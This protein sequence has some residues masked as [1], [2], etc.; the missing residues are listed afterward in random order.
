MSI[1]GSGVLRE[2]AWSLARERARSIASTLETEWVPVADLDGRVLGEDCFSR[3]PLPPFDTSAMDGWAVSGDG[4]WHLVGES[5]AGAPLRGSLI[6]GQAIRIATGAVVPVG[7]TSVV[8]WEEAEVSDGL[9]RGVSHSGRDIRRAGEECNTGEL[10]AHRGTDVTPALA[11]FLAATGHDQV[12][13]IR[14]PRVGLVL[15]GD[16]LLESGIPAD[17]RVRDSLGP[18][19]PGWLTRSGAEVVR[20]SRAPD[21]LDDIER[22]LVGMATRSDVVI[23]TGSTA[24]GPRDHLHA[25]IAQL[26]GELVVDRVAVRP[27]HPML[28]AVL[29]GED[30]RS[31]PLIGLPGNP[32]SAV[33]GLVTLGIPVIDAL[34]GRPAAPLA[35]VPA[36][37][38][39]RAPHGHTRLIAGVIHEGQFVLSP[40]GGSAMLRGLAQSSG[41][42]VVS[43]AHV[44][45]GELVPWLPLPGAE[46]A[47][48][49]DG[50]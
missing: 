30:G 4:P 26:R 49:G 23:T 41:F 38:E 44:A 25:V 15:L 37:E 48:S 16:E 10:I 19:L 42:A 29:R 33:V 50:H 28:M 32:H 47:R 40:Y 20:K 21:A 3:C 24:D 9:I 6:P 27:G 18:Q 35:Q 1:G 39:L 46:V 17:G 43:Q 2:C 34:L 36:T 5:L 8:R 7:A 12:A 13:V 22:A 11:G 14:R 45:T 31:V